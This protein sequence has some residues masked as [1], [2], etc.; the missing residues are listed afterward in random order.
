MVGIL[1]AMRI[2]VISLLI[3]L[4]F[5]GMTYYFFTE[6]SPFQEQKVQELIEANEIKPGEEDRLYFELEFIIE[7]GLVTEYLSAN[8][9][10][11]FFSGIIAVSLFFYFLYLIFDKLFFKTMI[12]PPNFAIGAIRSFEFGFAWGIFLL[13]KIQGIDTEVSLLVFVMVLGADMFF[14]SFRKSKKTALQ[15]RDL[16]QD[17]QIAQ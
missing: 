8:A 11:G 10:V 16:N 4:F 12:D 17:S 13:L 5:T 6:V 7:R 14:Q 2:A 3:A 9:Y 15:N 1:I